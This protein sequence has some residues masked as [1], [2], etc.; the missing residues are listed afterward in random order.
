LPPLA[1][2]EVEKLIADA[3]QD[4]GRAKADVDFT[5]ALYVLKLAFNWKT[6]CR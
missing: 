6:P 1:L 4:V 2:G 3:K 5:V